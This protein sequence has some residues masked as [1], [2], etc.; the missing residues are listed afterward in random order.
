MYR[1]LLVT[2]IS[3]QWQTSCLDRCECSMDQMKI[4]TN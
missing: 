1:E 3:Y 4:C 2:V